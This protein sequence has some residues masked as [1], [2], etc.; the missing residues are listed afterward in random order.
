ML[1]TSNA[2]LLSGETRINKIH[3]QSE[4]QVGIRQL[5]NQGGGGRAVAVNSVCGQDTLPPARDAV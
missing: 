4:S 2:P 1:R 5:E 3:K